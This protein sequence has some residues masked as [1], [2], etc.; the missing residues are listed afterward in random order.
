MK[1][2]ELVVLARK[3]GKAMSLVDDLL[4]ESDHL[5]KENIALRKL[6]LTVAKAGQS[7]QH[8]EAALQALIVHEV[9]YGTLDGSGQRPVGFTAATKA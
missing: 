3:G 4:A 2:K 9:L 5:R 1:N 6:V 7:P 8:R